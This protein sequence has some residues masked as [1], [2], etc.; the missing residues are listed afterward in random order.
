MIDKLDLFVDDPIPNE[1]KNRKIIVE[2]RQLFIRKKNIA[3]FRSTNAKLHNV[4]YVSKFEAN[5][6]SIS[7]LCEFKN[8]GV[9]DQRSITILNFINFDRILLRAKRSKH[10]GLYYVTKV[11]SEINEMT[12][13]ADDFKM[14]NVE[15][16]RISNL[17]SNRAYH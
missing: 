7:K 6:I 12:A 5:L 16:M 2:K 3:T 11:N 1:I 13:I 17:D 9:F 10:E 8:K 15:A 4:L 14:I